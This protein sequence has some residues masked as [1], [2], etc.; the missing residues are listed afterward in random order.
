MILIL[1]N[2]SRQPIATIK[3]SATRIIIYDI[4]ICRNEGAGWMELSEI[5]ILDSDNNL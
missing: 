3:M 1:L 4:D 2:A 5:K